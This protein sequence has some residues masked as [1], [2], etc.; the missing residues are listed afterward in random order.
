MNP[1]I[2]AGLIAAGISVVSFAFSAWTTSRTLQASRAASLRDR[3]AGVYQ[4]VLAFMSHQTETRRH[5]TRT[6]R[7]DAKTEARLQGQLD[8]YSP[9]DWFE[10]QSS[11]LAFCPDSVVHAFIASKAADDG[12]WSARAVHA[13][14]IELNRADPLA[15]DPHNA[16]ALQAEFRDRIRAA[17]Q[18]D[19]ELIEIVRDKMLGTRPLDANHSLLG[20]L[21][22]EVR[23]RQSLR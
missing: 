11:V 6:I 19:S 8:A 5:L 13:E 14:A 22:F 7:Y 1:T 10:L 4:Q 3:Q 12:V 15:S 20:M 21:I 17:E 16:V 9:P 23:S 2:A 18:T